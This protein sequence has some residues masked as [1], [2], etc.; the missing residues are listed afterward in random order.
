MSSK[1]DVPVSPAP[2]EV[3]AD[4]YFRTQLD[5]GNFLIQRCTA[6]ARSVFYPRML[7]PHCGDD[8]LEWYAPSGK[9]QVYSTTVVRRKA[10]HGGDYNVALIDLQE[11]VRM[12][13]RVENVEPGAVKIGLAVKAK[14]VD[15]EDGK[16]V[17]FSPAEGQQ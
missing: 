5:Q 4:L 14:V 7:C 11:G 9:G 3:G 16:L 6:C 10:E 13:S 12:M 15:A 8:H 17:V 1:T 2:S